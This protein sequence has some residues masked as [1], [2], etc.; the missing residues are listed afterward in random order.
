MDLGGILEMFGG[1][2]RGFCRHFGVLIGGDLGQILGGFLDFWEWI[3]GV[4]LELI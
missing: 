1:I 3:L 4:I 2:W